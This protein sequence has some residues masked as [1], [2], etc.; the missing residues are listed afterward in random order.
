MG[1]K[2]NDSRDAHPQSDATKTPIS[3]LA[4]HLTQ[5]PDGQLTNFIAREI[6]PGPAHLPPTHKLTLSYQSPHGV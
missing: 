6:G 5:T 4:R 2:H 3:E 1:D